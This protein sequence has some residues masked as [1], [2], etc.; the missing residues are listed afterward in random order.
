MN[1]YFAKVQKWEYTNPLATVCN[2]FLVPGFLINSVPKSGTHLLA[3]IMALFPGIRALGFDIR[4]PWWTYVK[5]PADSEVPTVSFG[6][7]WPR[8]APLSVVRQSFQL[9]TSKSG[10]FAMMHLLFSEGL[11]NL[12]SEIGITSL[13]ILRDPRDV[14]VSHVNFALRPPHRLSGH[15][16]KLSDHE[17]IMTSIVGV[18]PVLLNISD[19]YR[20]VL[21]WCSQ[22]FN[23]TTFFEK[24]IGPQGG[25]SYT[26]QIEELT[27]ITR[28]MGLRYGSRDIDRVA[29]QVFGGTG[30]FRKGVIGDW[31]NHFSEE[32]KRVFKELAGQLLIDLGYERDDDW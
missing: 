32:H 26:T 31:R 8:P 25:G 21:P 24:L 15:Y 28:H 5:Q 22:P 20:R 17:R 18:D 10:R 9:L 3:K 29:K 23:Y 11:A 19:R 30:T 12:F 7:E 13:L 14:V 16:Q 6:V 27:N 1:L 4:A 2:H